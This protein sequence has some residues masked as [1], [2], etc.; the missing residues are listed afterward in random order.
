MKTALPTLITIA[1]AAAIPLASASA[2]PGDD[3]IAIEAAWSKALVAKDM[4][5][6][7]RTVAPDWHGQN[8]GGKRIDR[9]TMLASISSGEDKITSITNHDV[10]V[11]LVGDLAIVQGMDDEVSTHKGK[12][13]SGT[14]GWTDVFQK[15]G[16]RWVAIASQGTLVTKQ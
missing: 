10:T 8:Q 6:L 14:Y 12:D 3:L 15:R 7:S 4:G 16:K 5:F 1:V 2:A 11:R 13:S 9:A